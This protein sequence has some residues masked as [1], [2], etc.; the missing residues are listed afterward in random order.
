MDADLEL[1]NHHGLVGEL[2][3]LIMTQPLN[4]TF[5]AKLMRALSLAGRPHEALDAYRGLQKVLKDELG[6]DPS[7][8]LRSLQ[9]AI[10]A[11]QPLRPHN[12]AVSSPI[13][14]ASADRV[15]AQLPPDIA[16]FA[17]RE[18]LVA[19]TERWLLAR[20]P[21]SSV[22]RVASLTGMPGV[23]KS[24]LA[25]RLAHNVKDHFPGGQLYAALRGTSAIPAKPRDVLN[26]F[27]RAAGALPDDGEL[28][29][30]DA[31]Q[32][33]RAWCARREVLIVLDD[34]ASVWQIEPLMPCNPRCA[35]IV[36]SR[37][38]YDLPGAHRVQVDPLPTREAL[39]LLANVIGRKRVDAE[40]EAAVEIL[41][42]VDHLPLA[43]RA[44]AARLAAAPHQ[45]LIRFADQLAAT[46]ARLT[47]LSVGDIDIRARYSASY[48]KLEEREKWAF[49]LLG[50]V[51]NHGFR[52]RDV[53]KLLG[54]TPLIVE[55]VL[56]RLV[57][58][59]LLTMAVDENGEA[60]FYTFPALTRIFARER[61]AEVAGTEVE[62]HHAG[63]QLRLVG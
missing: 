5:Y 4:E 25:T 1:G 50:L 52:S 62:L 33:F 13:V 57:E 45:P 19:E 9:R 39:Q 63:A 29:P 11:S 40:I 2:K 47:E 6:L 48:D 43:V 60:P 35:L 23:G 31:C 55:M 20:D 53:A 14:L 56:A 34:A 46:P 15:P 30:E 58:Y 7:A 49:R 26:N 42:L 54:C 28:E 44:A 38:M 18:R 36:T 51:G 41:Q 16:D 59:Q 21:R 32:L 24:A 17:G 37:C 3:A 61:L 12:P 27:L 8:E 22:G 10:L